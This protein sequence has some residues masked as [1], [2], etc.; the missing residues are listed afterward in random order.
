MEQSH[1]PVGRRCSKIKKQQMM[2]INRC[3]KVLFLLFSLIY[4]S[5]GPKQANLY[6]KIEYKLKNDFPFKM[7]AYDSLIVSR[8]GKHID[9]LTLYNRNAELNYHRRKSIIFF[10]NKYVYFEHFDRVLEKKK[11]FNRFPRHVGDTIRVSDFFQLGGG[12]YSGK[13]YNVG[14]DTTLIID[15]RPYNCSIIV[16]NFVDHVRGHKII[17]KNYVL[18]DRSLLVPLEITT[19]VRDEKNGKTD[20][21]KVSVYHIDYSGKRP[22]QCKLLN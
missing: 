10:N 3:S 1:P 9:V 11:P 4:L 20:T 5:C 2:T 21:V 15:Y 8:N 13:A 17:W 7:Y 6:Y 12:T 18:Y 14:I 16:E 19:T 22:I